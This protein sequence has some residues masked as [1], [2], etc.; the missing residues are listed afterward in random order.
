MINQSI[1][2]IELEPLYNILN[3]I[4]KNFNFEIVNYPKKNIFLDKIN[5]NQINLNN[6][7]ILLKKENY[8]FFEKINIDKKNI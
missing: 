5:S 2:I 6:A 1:H 3:E 7:I 8:N 4:E